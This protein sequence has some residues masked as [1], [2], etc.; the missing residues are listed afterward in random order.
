MADTNSWQSITQ[1]KRDTLDALL[2]ADFRLKHVPSAEEQKDV[3]QYIQQ[4]LSTSELDI[5]ENHSAAALVDKL[6]TGA[7]SATDVT[8]AFCH[9]ATIAHQLVNCLSEVL[10]SQALARAQ[11]L[12]E[13][14]RVNG[15][16]VGPLHGLPISLKDQF[17]VKDAET[18]V[19]YV[20]WLGKVETEETES[21]VVKALKDMGAIVFAK[22]NV[23]TSLMCIETNNN[24]VGY[25][26]N[27][28]NR[29][30]SSGGSSGGEAALL[31]LRGSI[32]GLGSDVGASIRLPCAFTGI[33]G[34][35]PSHGR[36]P[37]LNVANSM[38]G[39]DT[40]PSVIGPMGH[41]ISDLRLITQSILSSQPWLHDPKVIHLPWR[42]D[43]EDEVR[44][45]VASKTLTFGVL[46]TDGVIQPHPPVTR[47][48]NETVQA[49][50]AAG[51]EVI[52]W[53]PP[54]HAEAFQILWNAFAADGGID[55]HKTLQQSGEP[56]VPQLSV[57][58][59]EALGHLPVGTVNDLW[60][61]Q[62]A[63]YDYQARYLSYWNSTADQTRSGRPVDAI[64][65]PATP[66][67][68]HK[69]SDGIYPGYTGVYNVLDFSAAVIPVTKVDRAVDARIDDYN[70]SGDFDSAIWKQCMYP[71]SK[72]VYCPC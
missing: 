48:I 26:T 50:K 65:A 64:I 68:S 42:V 38:E 33:S 23:P 35:K 30:L 3:T 59:G 43:T 22:T 15:K 51:Y 18:S 25:T 61:N 1:R 69:P 45:S 4:F 29:L 8:R 27:P 7:L 16:P 37:Y 12:D 34:L 47:A 24:I 63:K 60:A 39:H 62:R 46:R 32:L 6:A 70:P 28:H 19:G 21:W 31:S 10:F 53:T 66:T 14:L 5:T 40:V 58:Y 2:P 55:I 20:A 41:T 57:S 11:E 72:S 9:R 52:E 36:L 44:Q 49:L 13:Y 17:R 67:A 71:I 56:P 54:P